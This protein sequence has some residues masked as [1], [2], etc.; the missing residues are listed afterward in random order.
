MSW[1]DLHRTK[2]VAR[3]QTD[4][5]TAQEEQRLAVASACPK[6]AVWRYTD[7]LRQEHA[8]LISLIISL[9]ARLSGCVCVIPRLPTNTTKTQL[10]FSPIP[11]FPRSL[12]RTSEQM[13]VHLPRLFWRCRNLKSGVFFHSPPS[14]SWVAVKD[15]SEGWMRPPDRW[16]LVIRSWVLQHTNVCGAVVQETCQSIMSNMVTSLTIK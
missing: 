7:S 12:I 11:P 13:D 1:R 4:K 15:R 5:S 6:W 14:Y 8:C 2:W 3:W 9:I 16:S 10:H